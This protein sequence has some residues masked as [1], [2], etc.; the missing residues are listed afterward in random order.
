M[1]DLWL[2]LRGNEVLPVVF[3]GINERTLLFNRCLGALIIQGLSISTDIN[4]SDFESWPIL[5]IKKLL[6]AGILLGF[7]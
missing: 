1:D 6:L 2:S 5:S 3:I 4:A 7:D